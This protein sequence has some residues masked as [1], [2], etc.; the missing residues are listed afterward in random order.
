MGLQLIKWAES[1]NIEVLYINNLVL[2]K[3]IYQP[4]LNRVEIFLEIER[5]HLYFENTVFEK[6]MAYCKSILVL[7]LVNFYQEISNFDEIMENLKWGLKELITQNPPEK[8]L[9]AHPLFKR[10]TDIINVLFESF[11]GV[12]HVKSARNVPGR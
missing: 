9:P 7:P 2:P 1:V 11:L 4:L 3:E 12:T 5:V 8:K 6:I 10:D